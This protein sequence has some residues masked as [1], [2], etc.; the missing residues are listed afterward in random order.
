MKIGRKNGWKQS[1]GEQR[2]T[3]PSLNIASALAPLVMSAR[4][5]LDLSPNEGVIHVQNGKPLT[6]HGAK[7][8]GV[9][10]TILD[11]V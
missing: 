11:R 2:H 5:E 6:A 8:L 9:P 4:K 10:W 7:L 3:R 1:V